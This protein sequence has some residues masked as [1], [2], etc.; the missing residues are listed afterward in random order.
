MSVRI[1]ADICSLLQCLI[2]SM[3]K[4]SAQV[5]NKKKQSQNSTQ[6]FADVRR[7]TCKKIAPADTEKCPQ[8]LTEARTSAD[9]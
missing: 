6:A 9:L 5:S 7:L 3:S 4:M 8:A 2:F 1:C